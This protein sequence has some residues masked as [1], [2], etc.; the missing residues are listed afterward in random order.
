MYFITFSRKAGANGTAIAKLVAKELQ[1]AFYDTEDIERKAAEMGFLDDVREVNDKM[2]PP[3]RRFFSYRTEVSLDRLYAVIYEL[4]RQ[5]SAIL[6]GRGGNMLL[7]S[8]PYALHVRI[9]ASREKRIQ[10]LA[11]R[12]YSREDALLVMQKSDHEREGFVKFAFRRNWDNS[13]LYDLVLNT[14]NFSVSA[15]AAVILAAVRARENWQSGGNAANALALMELAVKVRA[16]LVQAGFPAGYIS[17][18]VAA[19]GK[20]CLTGVVQV[21]WEKS[22][23]ERSV[24]AVAGVKTVENRIEI[25]GR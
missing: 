6:L 17:S 25:A 12:G 3:F 7:R 10:S 20:V 21:P 5:G 16:A 22:E 13:E 8:L 9:T 4:A 19:P 15:A 14:D 1:Y 2:P 24:L 11:E 23:A 18:F